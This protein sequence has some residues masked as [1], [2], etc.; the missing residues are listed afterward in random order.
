MYL[1]KRI[2]RGRGNN[3]LVCGEPG[4]GKSTRALRG[5]EAVD[6]NGASI[7]K[8]V[9]DSLEFT[10]FLDQGKIHQGDAIFWDENIG[11]EAM[12]WATASNKSIK[13]SAN[14]MRRKNF[15]LFMALPSIK[16]LDPKLR[17]LFHFYIEPVKFDEAKDG[18]YCLFLRIQ[19]NALTGKTYYKHFRVIDKVTRNIYFVG[20]VF[21]KKPSDKLME[22]YERESQQTKDNIHHEDYIEIK[23]EAKK[24]L[25]NWDRA[26]NIDQDVAD[27][28][29]NWDNIKERSEKKTLE[30]IGAFCE[31]GCDKSARILAKIRL[32]RRNSGTKEFLKE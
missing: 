19:H 30:N 3:V 2:K 23:K 9:R 24:K 18:Y 7:S 8:Y 32:I 20:L 1:I 10:E 21:I 25:R 31:V 22:E 14:V 11:A 12:N 27:V 29:N 13:R 5:M 28:M 26:S 17:H 4:G 6:L 16:D 15:T